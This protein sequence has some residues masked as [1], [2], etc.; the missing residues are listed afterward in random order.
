MEG[1]SSTSL[2]VLEDEWGEADMAGYPH[3]MLKEI[4]EQPEALRRCISGRLDKANGSAKLG[5][6]NLEPV[7]LAEH[8]LTFD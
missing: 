2:T 7:R 4:H 8:H 3:Y 6:L 1:S 5:G